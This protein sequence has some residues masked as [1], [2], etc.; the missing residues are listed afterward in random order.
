MHRAQIVIEA[1]Q[2]EALKAMA[3]RRGISI[4][5]VVREILDAALSA[6][7]SETSQGLA[8]IR[9][10]GTDPASSGRDHDRFLYDP[11]EGTS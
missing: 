1:W 5:A 3:S 9:G 10:I 2:H 7:S 8:G 4:S 6:D 11:Q